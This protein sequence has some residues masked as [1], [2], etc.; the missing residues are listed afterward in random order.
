[1]ADIHITRAMSVLYDTREPWGR[2]NFAR[3]AAQ[4]DELMNPLIEKK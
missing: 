3:S 2:N 4:R 1:M